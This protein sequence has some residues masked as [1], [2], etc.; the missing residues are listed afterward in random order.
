MPGSYFYFSPKLSGAAVLPSYY[1]CNAFHHSSFATFHFVLSPHARI[2]LGIIL[3]SSYCVPPCGKFLKYTTCTLHLTAI[4]RHC[5]NLVS[6]CSL[7]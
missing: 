4:R 1:F 7:C 5:C 6:I 2:V 3:D